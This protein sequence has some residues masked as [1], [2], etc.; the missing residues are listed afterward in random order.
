MECAPP[1]ENVECLPKGPKVV[2]FRGSY[3]EFYKVIPRRNYFGAYGQA[4]IRMNPRQL[5][6]GPNKLNLA[7]ILVLREIE[8][9]KAP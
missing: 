7:L 6:L 1:D 8:Y 3:L 5:K 9:P 2:P 4:W